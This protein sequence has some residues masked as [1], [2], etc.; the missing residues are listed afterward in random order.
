LAIAQNSSKNTKHNYYIKSRTVLLCLRGKVPA[1]KSQS[2]YFSRYKV[3]FF[4][5]SL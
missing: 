5:D 4:E 3:F 2:I 1:H